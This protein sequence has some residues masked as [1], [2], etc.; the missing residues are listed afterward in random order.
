MWI[1]RHF[2]LKLLSLGLALMLWIAVAGE[3]IVER[4]LRVPLE[5][6][7]SPASL[8]LLGEPPVAVDVRV[9]GPSTTLSRV[10]TGDVFA[11]LDLHGAGPGRRLFHLTPEQVRAPFGVEVAQV[12][13]ATVALAFEASATKSVKVTPSVEGK[14][15]PGY[16]VGAV[17][18]DPSVV[19]VVGPESA[20]KR[21][22]EAMTES[23]SITGARDRVSET[24]SVGLFD[25]SL[26]LKGARNA[27]VSVQVLPGPVEHT[28]RAVAI[29]LRNLAA[30]LSAEAM[31]E[32]VTVAV[33]GSREGL[34]HVESDD[35]NVFVD[36][37]GLGSG[38]YTATVH[39]VVSPD[40]GVVRIDPPTV[41]V[42]ITSARK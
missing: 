32:A 19:D 38:V 16:V 1:F 36:L 35:V 6:Q 7:Q 37:S 39:G 14:P 17:S 13:P 34:N 40:A 12:S 15:A 9:R 21:V 24:V 23:V 10:G 20:V 26:R 5:L 4:G 2:G 29:H 30:G 27:T 33:R 41:Q 11:V 42:R 18:I 22:T 25:P 28:F 3:E 8:E 31:P